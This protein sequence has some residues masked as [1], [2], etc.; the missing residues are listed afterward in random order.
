V[1]EWPFYV[2]TESAPPSVKAHERVRG[3]ID[4]FILARLEREGLSLA[5]EATRRTLIRRLSYDLI[6]L[7]PSSEEVE[8]FVADEDPTAYEK[9]VDRLLDDKR[10]GERWARLW[11]DLARYADTAGYEGDPDLPH[12]WRYRDYV[13]D[14]FNNDKRYDLFIKEQLAGDE[15]TQIMGAGDLPGTKPEHVVALTFL[16]LA[17]F[18]EPRGD[19][20][21]HEFLSEITGTVGS[22]FLGLT[23]GCAQCHDHKYDKIPTRD[24]YRM[25]AFFSTV[26][27]TRPEP[28]DI[29]QI[30]GP[31]PADF[32]R[33]GEKDWAS[34]TRARFEREI[35]ESKTELAELRKS[36]EKRFGRSSSGIGI[37]S[38]GGDLGNNYRFGTRGVNDGELHVGL[39]NSN[40]G[41]WSFFTDGEGPNS[42][43]SLAGGNTGH[44]YGDLRDASHAALGAYTKGTGKPL[45]EGEGTHRGHFAEI[46]VYDHPLDENE[47]DELGRYVATKYDGD[48]DA[49]QLPRGSASGPPS[50]GLRFWLDSADLDANPET[51]NPA[52]GSA[53][54]SWTDRISGVTLSQKDASRQPKLD[55]LG[56]AKMPAVLF[57]DDILV[58]SVMGAKFLGD[59]RGALVKIFSATH[60]H[61]G[62][63]FEVGGG[64]AFVSSVIHPTASK[65]SSVDAIVN[66]PNSGV[67][68][69]ER[70]RYRY[71]KRAEPFIK[72]RLKR[73]RPL[74]MSLRHSYGPPFEPGVPTTH[75]MIRGEYDSLGEAVKAGFPSCVTG[76]EKPAAIRLDPFK[77]WPTRSRR[78]ALAGWIASGDNPLTARVMVNRLWHWHF[79]RGIVPTPSDFGKLS[80]GPSHRELLDWLAY[81][82]VKEKW[83]VKKMHRLMVTSSTYRQSSA[84]DDPVASEKDAGNTLLWRFRSRRLEAEAVR[85]AILAVSG[86]LNPE[87][88]GLPIFPPLPGDIAETVKFSTSKWDVQYGPD[89]R[90]RSIYIYQQRTLSMPFLQ[91]FDAV[92]C[93]TSRPRR[94]SSVTALQA[95]S[96]YNGEFVNDEARFFAKRVAKAAGD[97]PDGRVRHAFLL[98]FSR[99]PTKDENGRMRAF[100]AGAES[101]EEGLVGLC[102]ILFNANEFVYVD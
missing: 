82:F 7:P 46:L 29:F 48:G 65:G 101:A 96:L 70:R 61:E 4:S 62:Y 34:K 81:R 85:D 68:K 93:D 98:A 49:G 66:D 100:L 76:H 86:R 91:V 32:Y 88:F 63:G 87:Q 80:G 77:R 99:P 16:R 20:S 17:P 94:R 10:Y 45:S 44:W 5:P 90:K 2:P 21:R 55:V 78:M 52:V 75:V 22:V 84:R 6:G 23:V 39:I 33:P 12:A 15:F 54:S 47:R 53:V 41:E 60:T 79:G 8:A 42:T 9:L 37:Q 89:G 26:S 92:V 40:G 71:L 58:G 51:P 97:D 59:R 74:A 28:G 95:L 35:G 30:G 25:K 102:R 83:S 64:G 69:E 1:R 67:S 13:I 50:R 14:A 24:F 11:L 19:E 3:A 43:G 73:L 31:L 18:T 38:S 56:K 72:Q 57:H 36:F 27:M